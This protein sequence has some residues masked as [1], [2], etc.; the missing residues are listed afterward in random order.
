VCGQKN[1]RAWVDD[2][3]L[4]NAAVV[5]DILESSVGKNTGAVFAQ[6]RFLINSG[7]SID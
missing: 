7:N 3:T 4:K 5:R 6:K 2:C 1:N